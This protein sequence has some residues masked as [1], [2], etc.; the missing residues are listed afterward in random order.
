ML[1]VLAVS[2]TG[3]LGTTLDRPHKVL[4]EGPPSPSRAGTRGSEPLVIP[5]WPPLCRVLPWKLTCL[6]MFPSFVTG[7]RL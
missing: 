2:S 7:G 6:P 5:L 4:D 3:F 1:Q